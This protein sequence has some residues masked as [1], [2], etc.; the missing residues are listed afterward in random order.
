M[1]QT[2]TILTCIDMAFR[3]FFS[4]TRCSTARESNSHLE[5][6]HAAEGH[7]GRVVGDVPQRPR[8]AADRSIIFHLML[9]LAP[10]SPNGPGAFGTL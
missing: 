4:F 5:S 6:T 3:L 8:T 1:Q 9:S 7:S 10:L 2:H